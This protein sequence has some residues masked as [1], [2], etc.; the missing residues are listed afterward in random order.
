[1]TLIQACPDTLRPVGLRASASGTLAWRE[2]V[3]G[4]G[5]GQPETKE[6]YKKSTKLI[7][8]LIGT[9]NYEKCIHLGSGNTLFLKI[10]IAS[11][12]WWNIAARNTVPGHY[13]H[14]TELK[15]FSKHM[16][17]YPQFNG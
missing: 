1:M 14:K 9:A 4:E 3:G 10:S 2:E 7:W 12:Q 15:V 6:N 16:Y 8:I 17:N 5:R 13:S 11:K